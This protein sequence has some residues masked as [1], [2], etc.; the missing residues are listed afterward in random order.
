MIRGIVRLIVKT[1]GDFR[2]ATNV[3]SYIAE[4]FL[5]DKVDKLVAALH[6][7]LAC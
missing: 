7:L 3:S 1:V 4:S 2:W 5:S 6:T